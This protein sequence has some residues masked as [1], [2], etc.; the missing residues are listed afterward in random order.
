MKKIIYILIISLLLVWVSYATATIARESKSPKLVWQWT[1]QDSYD[2]A[3]N[4][5]ASYKSEQD[6]E[7]VNWTVKWPS[8][9][10]R[11]KNTGLF[12]ESQ[13]EVWWK[14]WEEAK[15]YCEALDKW[16][17]TNWRLPT[18]SELELLSDFSREDK[19]INTDYFTIKIYEYYWSSTPV[20]AA[21]SPIFWDFNLLGAQSHMSGNSSINY[22]I[23][24]AD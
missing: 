11:D 21:N 7:F 16:W 1:A 12:W 2:K 17:K 10:V 20:S 5:W 22:F 19:F 15:A 8:W 4:V 3:H 24:V 18:I 6:F 14:T 9:V 13:N 23:C